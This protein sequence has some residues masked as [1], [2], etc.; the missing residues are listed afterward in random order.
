MFFK[1]LI[2]SVVLLPTPPKVFHISLELNAGNDQAITPPYSK[3]MQSLFLPHVALSISSANKNGI[4][5]RALIQLSYSDKVTGNSHTSSGL[6]FVRIKKKKKTKKS[7]TLRVLFCP[8]VSYLVI[9]VDMLS[10]KYTYSCTLT[11]FFKLK[12]IQ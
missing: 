4:T 11:V 8:N 9:L 5:L 1:P 12:V 3:L 7:N 10:C 2:A 6:R